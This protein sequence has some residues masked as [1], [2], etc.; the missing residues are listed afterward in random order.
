MV[1]FCI[2]VAAAAVILVE[3]SFEFKCT[4][5]KIVITGTVAPVTLYKHTAFY[6]EIILRIIH[7]Y[8]SVGSTI[9]SLAF[10][11]LAYSLKSVILADCYTS[12][13]EVK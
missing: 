12:V 13:I 10:I 3:A 1:F 2:K 4:V 8:S 9:Y 5:N 6:K 7:F 11:I